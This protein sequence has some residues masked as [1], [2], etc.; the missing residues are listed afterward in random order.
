MES[1]DLVLRTAAASLSL[2]VGFV[3]GLLAVEHLAYPADF[4][5]FAFAAALQIGWG[6]ATFARSRTGRW[7]AGSGVAIHVACC[8][9]WGLSR[10][11]GLPLGHHAGEV[12]PVGLLDSAVTATQFVVAAATLAMVTRRL[13]GRV[14]IPVA[15]TAMLLARAA[16]LLGLGDAGGGGH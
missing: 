3:H 10:L 1:S 11:V 8:G 6:A 9:A 16:L 15:V 7:W 4:G 14:A 13:A 5:L 12:Q 2:A